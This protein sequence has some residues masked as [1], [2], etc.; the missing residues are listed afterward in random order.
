MTEFRHAYHGRTHF[1]VGSDP[2]EIGLAPASV[3][4]TVIGDAN[5]TTGLQLYKGTLYLPDADGS[6]LTA[7]EEIV[8]SYSH[9]EGI[10]HFTW[11]AA[12]LHAVTGLAKASYDYV[13]PWESDP[14]GGG[15]GSYAA[16]DPFPVF[17][18]WVGMVTFA[19]VTDDDGETVT[20]T[21]P[22]TG[23]EA[24]Q[25]SFDTGEGHIGYSFHDFGGSR[26]AGNV[27][28]AF[29]GSSTER[30]GAI[31][32]LEEDGSV[33]IGDMVGEEIFTG[34]GGTVTSR[35]SVTLTEDIPAGTDL[36]I[37]TAAKGTQGFVATD[38]GARPQ[39]FSRVPTGLMVPKYRIG[40]QLYNFPE[41]PIVGTTLPDSID[42]GSP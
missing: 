35:V 33:T 11:M 13:H 29:S 38:A 31:L 24:E 12:R 16:N 39:V 8:I 15:I 17:G 21:Y 25:Y 32:W 5:L 7:G 34:P 2:G 30:E 6:P 26:V 9:F 42:G 40:E 3:M 36:V 4:G 18:G 23:A 37:V 14:W 28:A 22:D 27:T 1:L 10:N 20:W 41:Q 19:A